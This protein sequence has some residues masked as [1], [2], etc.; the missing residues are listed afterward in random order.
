MKTKICSKCKDAQ[1]IDISFHK[2]ART[3][4]GYTSQCKS[5]RI[6]SSKIY[7]KTERGK[8]QHRLQESIRRS[9]NPKANL[10]A[11][12]KQRAKRKN[13]EFS[14]TAE[15]INIPN[16]C[17]VLGIDIRSNSKLNDNSPSIDR[18]NNSLGYIPGNVMVISWRANR[19]KSDGSTL[20][21]EKILSYMYKHLP[22]FRTKTGRRKQERPSKFYT[23]NGKS[24]GL[25]DWAD[26]YKMPYGVLNTRINR[27]GW[28]FEKAIS[29]PVRKHRKEGFY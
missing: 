19:L 14:I 5:C 12:A 6:N 4:D 7:Y 26:E 29:T 21:L 20:E 27:D 2:D 22:E 25:I 28:E 15:D 16:V 11:L 18:I 3:I 9:D 1:D 24:Q 17:P 23:Y 8:E 10:L 13:I